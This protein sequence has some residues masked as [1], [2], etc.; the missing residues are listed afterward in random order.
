[1]RLFDVQYVAAMAEFVGCIADSDCTV[2][3]QGL[4]ANNN[5]KQKLVRIQVFLSCTRSHSF[6][7]Q[8]SSL[9]ILP[10][11][12]RSLSH[13]CLLSFLKPDPHSPPPESEPSKTLKGGMLLVIFGMALIGLF[14]PFLLVNMRHMAHMGGYFN[15]FSGGIFLTTGLT[16]IF[17]DAISSQIAIAPSIGNYPLIPLLSVITF[18]VLLFLERVILH[19]HGT[20]CTAL[21]LF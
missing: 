8:C 12:V 3:G 18:Y 21:P 4:G 13:S 11:F 7:I 16:H 9:P 5:G 10:R 19:T 20:H 6:L 17:M 2:V 15:A 14:L 1:M